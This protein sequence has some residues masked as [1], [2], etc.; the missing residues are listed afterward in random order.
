MTTLPRI[1]VVTPS[2]NQGR[3]IERTIRSVV[4]QDY[5]DVEYLVVD[6][7]STDE[8]VDVLRR[9]DDRIDHW[10]SEPDRGQAHAINKG[11]RRATGDVVGWLNS[12]DILLPGALRAVAELLAEG[13]PFD[14]VVGHCRF[15]YLP[16]GES[17]VLRGEYV[18]RDRLLRF[19]RGYRMHQPAI[20]W[21]RSVTEAIGYLDEDLPLTMDFDYWVRMADH[22][23]FVN[24]DRVLAAATY[25]AE[26][27]TGDAYRGYYAR[28]RHDAPR[29]WGVGPTSPRWWWLEAQMRAHQLVTAARRPFNR[30]ELR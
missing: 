21:R 2:F 17:V 28:L 4:D 5:P 3:F 29:Y 18:D 7:G 25:H 30:A 12:D 27:K 13:Q 10:V 26:A 11:L 8:T 19:W 23:R 1:T 22:A 15:D 14:V 9:Y 24:C 6:G 16:S 20:W